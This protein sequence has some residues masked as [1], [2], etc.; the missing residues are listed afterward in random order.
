MG[1]W[2]IIKYISLLSGRL[3]NFKRKGPS[4]FNFSC[5]FCGDSDNKRKARAYIYEREGKMQF[6][7][8]NCNVTKSAANF[9]KQ[10]DQNLYDEYVM[11]RMRENRTPEQIDKEE[12]FEKL[13][14]PTYLLG[15]PLKGLRKVSQLSANN[16]IKIFIDS[17]KIPNP[18]HAK[19]FECCNFKNFTNNLIPN[20]FSGESLEKDETRLLIPYFDSNNN[21]FAYNCRAI[22]ASNVK[23]IKILLREDIPNLYGLESINYDEPVYVFE[24]EIDSMFIN[25]SIAT[26]GGDLISAVKTLQKNKLV[27]VYD[28]EKRSPE[29]VKKIDKAIFQGYNVVIW[30][31]NLDQKDINEMVLSGLSV[32]FIEHILKTNTYREL[33]AKA[34]L[35]EWSKT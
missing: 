4:L 3:R 35:S 15:G 33:A 2:L 19:L 14:K 22:G 17:R 23:Y 10:M 24:G 29:T 28:N 26:G 5:S 6:H 1:D 31:E 9:I 30:P 34:K 13:K 16:M 27:I 7:C 11:E 18:Y 21:V 20:K 8:H 12:F 32:E 25:N